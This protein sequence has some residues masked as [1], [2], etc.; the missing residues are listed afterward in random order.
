MLTVVSSRFQTSI[1]LLRRRYIPCWSW[2]V[3]TAGLVTIALSVIQRAFPLLPWPGTSAPPR[4]SPAYSGPPGTLTRPSAH[5]GHHGR[6]HPGHR[7][8]RAHPRVAGVDGVDRGCLST[9]LGVISVLVIIIAMVLRIAKTQVPRPPEP[10]CC[11]TD[12]D[13]ACHRSRDP[14]R[15]RPQ[16]RPSRGTDGPQHRRRPPATSCAST[17][18]SSDSRG[19]HA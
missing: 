9:I 19:P 14:G 15:T 2:G 17:S 5:R 7:R 4:P 16:L 13:R 6:L 1:S 8:R 3:A 10:A 18:P 12:D 11:S